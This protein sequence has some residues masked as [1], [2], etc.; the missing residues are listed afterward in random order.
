[1]KIILWAVLVIFLIG[2][3]VVTGVF[4]MIF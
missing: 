3:L 4:K 2:L 1:M